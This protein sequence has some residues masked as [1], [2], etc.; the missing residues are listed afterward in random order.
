MGDLAKSIEM[1]GDDE[2]VYETAEE[3]ETE[4][5]GDEEEQKVEKYEITQTKTKEEE[6]TMWPGRIGSFNAPPSKIF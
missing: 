3:D 4:E 1:K 2:D 5:T 6:I